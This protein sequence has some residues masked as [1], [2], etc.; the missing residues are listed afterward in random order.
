LLVED[1]VDEGQ[2]LAETFSKNV[3]RYAGR[4]TNRLIKVLGEGG[5]Y[6]E[7]SR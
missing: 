5:A 4:S 1:E 7:A 2:R 6:L 3:I